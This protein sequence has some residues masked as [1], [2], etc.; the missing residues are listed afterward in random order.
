[1]SQIAKHLLA[2]GIVRAV[3]IVAWAGQPLHDSRPA[4]FMR[5]C[6]AAVAIGLI[7]L[8]LVLTLHFAH[9]RD[10]DGRYAGSPWFDSLKSKN[11]PCCSG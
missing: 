3:L 2:A 8:V 1:M 11:G 6:V 5:V 7:A 4:L 10:L 9:A